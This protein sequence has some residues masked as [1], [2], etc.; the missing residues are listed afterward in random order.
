MNRKQRRAQQRQAGAGPT[1][2]ADAAAIDDRLR[3]AA[4]LRDAQQ[5]RDAVEIYQSVLAVAPDH[6]PTL[7]AFGVTA[8][9]AGETALAVDLLQRAV[10]A[11]GADGDGYLSDLGYALAAAERFDEAL[12]VYRQAV[13]AR[14]DDADAHFNLGNVL[15]A[16]DCPG[17]AVAAYR[18]AVAA[19]PD[20]VAAHANLG[21]VLH[22]SADYDGAAAAYRRALELMPDSPDL[23]HN[24]GAVYRSLGDLEA[25]AESYEQA[26]A[27]APERPDFQEKLGASLLSLGRAEAAVPALRAAVSRAPDFV[28]ARAGLAEAL[29]GA[30]APADAIAECDEYLDAFGYNSGVIACKAIALNETGDADGARYFLDLDR[31][32]AAGVVAAPTGYADLAAF[33]ADIEAEARAHPS[34]AFEPPAVATKSGY[35]TTDLFE[36]P[37]P[38]VAALQAVVNGAVQEYI[39]ALPDDPNHPFIANA[40][41]RRSLNGWTVILQ[42]QGHQRAHI[43]P[44][45]WLSGVFYV[46]VPASIGA[47]SHDGWIEFGR[48]PDTILFQHAMET[49]LF[50]PREGVMLLFPSYLYHR[51]IPFDGDEE[52]ISFAFDIVAQA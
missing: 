19:A 11:A 37:T 40:P 34:L 48:P 31:F 18:D 46:K 35:Q 3:E 33:R 38:A 9:L 12:T 16:L 51:T 7:R 49:R 13:T 30:G 47:D 17:E 20:M 14:P 36:A 25:A 29:I 4:R 15:N 52:R 27:L 23:H 6:H 39:D 32:V 42:S 1:G 5:F 44:S 26:V 45:G 28:D 43:H 8:I 50:E 10:A 24:L 2:P 21:G 41:A 22:L